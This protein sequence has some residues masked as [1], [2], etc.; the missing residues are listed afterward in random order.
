M[1]ASLKTSGDRGARVRR[2][3]SITRPGPGGKRGRCGD[4][5]AGRRPS[6]HRAARTGGF[7]ARSVAESSAAWVYQGVRCA[8]LSRRDVSTHRAHRERSH[9]HASDNRRKGRR[10]HRARDAARLGHL[11]QH[12]GRRGRRGRRAP[13]PELPAGRGAAPARHQRWPVSRRVRR[14]L[15]IALTAI[16]VTAASAS[17][18]TALALPQDPIPCVANLAVWHG[19][20]SLQDPVEI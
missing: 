7:S 14:Q 4:R 11:W 3:M 6:D 5:R 10:P 1:T 12:R 13:M 15:G 2:R 17:T 18:G 16:L 9:S 8:A 20:T 19:H